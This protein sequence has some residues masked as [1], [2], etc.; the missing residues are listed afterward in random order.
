MGRG[1]KYHGQGARLTM[2]RGLNISWIGGSGLY[3]I[4]AQVM[5]QHF[6]WLPENDNV[7]GGKY[8]VHTF[9]IILH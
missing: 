2:D 4:Q 5:F 9:D 7:R 1:S 6:G 8:Y 3:I